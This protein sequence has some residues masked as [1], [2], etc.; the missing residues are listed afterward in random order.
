MDSQRVR[1]ETRIQSASTSSFLRSV[2]SRFAF[3]LRKTFHQTDFMWVKALDMLDVQR[4]VRG[5]C[6]HALTKRGIFVE[7]CFL[8]FKRRFVRVER[9]FA[10][11]LVDV[12]IGNGIGHLPVEEIIVLFS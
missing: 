3:N 2:E 9:M 11:Q 1:C 6:F 5:S 12:L 10:Q 4:F 7:T 8:R